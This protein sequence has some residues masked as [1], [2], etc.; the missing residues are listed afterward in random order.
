MFIGS[1]IR[2]LNKIPNKVTIACSGGPDS[3]AALDFLR[4]GRREVRAAYF[5]HGTS[6]GEFAFDK[7]KSYCAYHDIELLSARIKR[8]RHPEESLEEYWRNER[9]KFLNS[10]DGDVITAHTLDDCIEWWIF[11]SLHGNP[12]LIPYKNENIIRPFLVTQKQNLINWCERK[13]VSYVVDPGN[14]NL[15]FARSRIRNQIIPEALYINPGLCKVLK[16]KIESS[17]SVNHTA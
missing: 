7:V 9:K 8:E 1:M 6:H 16:K 17:F 10:I 12:R 13:N 14:T 11:T 5:N 2:I 15:R 3:M 4:R